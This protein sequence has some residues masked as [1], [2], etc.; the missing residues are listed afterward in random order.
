MSVEEALVEAQIEAERAILSH[1]PETEVAAL[2]EKVR[3]LGGDEAVRATEFCRES[4]A[5]LD[6]Y[7]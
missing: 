2:L 5:M 4:L 3:A 7:R 6:I 1:A